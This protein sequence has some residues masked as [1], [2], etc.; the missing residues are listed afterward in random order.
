M[1]DNIISIETSSKIC[2]VS[3]YKNNLFF[4]INLNQ[5]LTHEEILFSNLKKLLDENEVSIKDLSY[6][7]VSNGPG[8]YTGLRIG[9][10]CAIGLSIIDNIE[11]RYV[12]TLKSLSYNILDYADNENIDIDK[13]DK[14]ISIIDAKANRVY[15]A[16]SNFND[17]NS[18]IIEKIVSIDEL[19]D[20]MNSYNENLYLL[21]D[22]LDV[23]KDIILTNYKKNNMILLN[24]KYNLLNSKNIIK[25][26]FNNNNY[27]KKLDINYMQKSQAE[28]NR[29]MNV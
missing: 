1:N 25:A 22:G 17:L 21:G 28:R 8:S 13:N 27:T 29:L 12:N 2:S 19:I 24:D 5:G 11:I 23:Y 4:D 26:S 15:L 6:I 3:L 10:A 14:I 18:F 7:A 20:I 16:V 9:I